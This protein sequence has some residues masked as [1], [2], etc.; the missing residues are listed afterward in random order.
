M[1]SNDNNNNSNTNDE[2]PNLRPTKRVAAGGKSIFL[3][4]NPNQP[5]NKSYIHAI[6]KNTNENSSNKQDPFG[7]QQS[8]IEYSLNKKQRWEILN[9]FRRHITNQ[10]SS[11][12]D[13]ELDIQSDSEQQN[14]KNSIQK[15][16]KFQ[17]RD[18]NSHQTK[19]RLYEHHNTEQQAT[20][21]SITSNT[22]QQRIQIPK[23]TYMQDP[24]NTLKLRRHGNVHTADN[25]NR[26][27][28]NVDVTYY[29]VVPPPKEKQLANIRKQHGTKAK[30]AVASIQRSKFTQV[31]DRLDVIEQLEEDKEQTSTDDDN[32]DDEPITSTLQKPD[33]LHLNDFIPIV[34]I[35]DNIPRTSI[36]ENLITINKFDP[37]S[38]CYYIDDIDTT[39]YSK[40][41]HRQISREEKLYNRDKAVY[42][43][44]Q[45]DHGKNI[46]TIEKTHHHLMS[47]SF[48][49]ILIR[50]NDL[51]IDYL[52]TTY[53]KNFIHAQ[54]YPTKYLICLTDRLKSY[55]W[56]N[57]F[58][59]FPIYSILNSYLII[60]LN[61]EIK[62]EENFIRVQIGLNM[63]L[64]SDTIEIENLFESTES[65]YKINDVIEKTI[66][67]I[68]IL[69]F[70]TFKPIDSEINRKKFIENTEDSEL[71]ESEF[72]NK[73][74]RH[75]QLLDKNQTRTTTIENE[76][77]D[78]ID[79]SMDE[80]ELIKPDICT[81]CYRD[82][83]ET[84]P[85]T[86][87]K[88]CA[89]WF[90]NDCWKQYLENSIK[91][92][93]VI[94]CPEWNCCSMVDVGTMLSLVNVRCM[95][96]YERNIEKCLVNLSRSYVKC[97]LK[98]CSNVVQ[99][100]GSRIDH[101]RCRCGHRFCI[102]CKQE[103]HFPATCSAYRLYIDEVYR[104]GDLI[105]DY[106]AITQIKGRNCVS[107]NNFIEK[108]GGCNHM[109]CSC[110]AE[111]CWTC[112]GYW[113][114][115]NAP[116][117]TFRCPKE[118]IPLQEEVIAKQHNQSR[119]FYYNAILHRHQR[120]FQLQSKQNENAKRLLG[121]IPLDKGTLFDSTN[122]K[123]QIDKRESVL[124][125]LYEMV[126]YIEYLHC[127]C[128]FIAVSAEGYGNNPREFRN[129]LQPL[130]TIVFN[131]SQILEGGKG[132]K[133]IEQ[134]NQLHTTSEKIIERLRRAVTLRELRRIQTTGYVT[135]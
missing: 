56:L 40:K 70:D 33:K 58:Q 97:P 26:Q 131:M 114:D 111:F 116:D 8:D 60:I 107:C 16:K 66:E 15:K 82:I 101:V 71:S 134:I 85:M 29:A 120:I 52:I 13:D 69:P 35:N 54:C 73:Q 132:Y 41:F 51:N 32:D 133:A 25:T 19:Y 17:R 124:R 18:K 43:Q 67:F 72:L 87:L 76:Q 49:S 130:E 59:F 38:S 50:K 42:L 77:L 81:N 86:A 113:K 74:I 34:S 63:D 2:K 53:G 94:V 46:Q 119:R 4:H 45:K 23:K 79:I 75:V 27:T 108:N 129:S 20:C 10:S 1:A 96:I 110:G 135:S 123:S 6:W 9:D 126:K 125:H 89:H 90:C 5:S 44:M 14:Q 109:T 98:S 37:K 84:I 93:N 127:I 64:Y 118:T 78:N 31:K 104:N 21:V 128:E 121:T 30:K 36:T 12:S 55:K 68:T 24:S 95:N 106:N 22:G 99:V 28:T 7:I 62:N 105:S 11:S 47:L 48:R 65:I 39:K 80:Y 61:D 100:I 88:S 103:R 92:V 117:G 112:T 83:N 115:H 122:I 57:K 102:N 91:R 3:H